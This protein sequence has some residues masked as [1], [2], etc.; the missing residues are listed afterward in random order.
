MLAAFFNAKEFVIM[1]ILRQGTSFTAASFVGNVILPLGSREAQ[2]RGGL[3]R[4]NLHL[5]FQRP[6]SSAS[7]KKW[8]TGRPV[9][10]TTIFI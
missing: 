4:H 2:E 8:P 6:L 7:T 1:N 10:P 3:A 9:F 5:H